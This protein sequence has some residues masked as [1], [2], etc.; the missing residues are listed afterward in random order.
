M[1]KVYKLLSLLLILVNCI[2]TNIAAEDLANKD[3]SIISSKELDENLIFAVK[4]N[5]PIIVRE[6]VQAGADISGKI[7]TPSDCGEFDV[8]RTMTE[9][10]KDNG[11]EDI[12][13]QLIMARINI[14]LSSAILAA[15]EANDLNAV[16]YLIK[17]GVNARYPDNSGRALLVASD[18]GHLEVVK[19]LIRGGVDVNFGAKYFYGSA[20][21]IASERGHLD[22]IRELIK[23]GADV[24][25]VDHCGNTCL[26]RA[27]DGYYPSNE[28]RIK[29]IN[30]IL[31]AKCNVN[32][33][34]NYNKTALKTAIQKNDSIVVSRLIE[35]GADI[36]QQVDMSPYGY[37][38]G[39]H[40]SFAIKIS[41][42]NVLNQ[43]KKSKKALIVA[44]KEGLFDFVKEL[45]QEGCDVNSLDND[46]NTALIAA[47]SSWWKSDCEK[48]MKVLLKANCNVNHTNIHGNTALI[49]AVKLGVYK[50][51]K[52]LLEH[53]KINIKHVNKDG[54]TALKIA[55]EKAPNESL[56]YFDRNESLEREMIANVLKKI[57]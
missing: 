8:I 44:S 24:N 38:K 48:I 36:G 22:L 4:N 39:S 50:A 23:K 47:L 7:T 15:S 37:G 35:A 26:M 42:K 55:M 21:I 10:A 27:I 32:H 30:L 13:K 41:N 43:L 52:I 31:N 11:Y 46:R 49:E 33:E 29:A 12:E 51:V 18:K 54:K 14:N 40:L 5:L 28:N 25:A 3:Y 16:K 45:V 9:Y 20:L 17:A 57:S 34:N 19:E 6:L 1:K 2:Q 56:Y 53:P